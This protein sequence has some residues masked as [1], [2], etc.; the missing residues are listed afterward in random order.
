MEVV[1]KIHEGLHQDFNPYDQPANT[2]QDN[3]NGI[4]MDMQ[5][6]NYMWTNMKGTL[7]VFQI[8]DDD[9][10]MRHCLIR[11]RLF[12]IVYNDIVDY[13]ILYELTFDNDGD[14]T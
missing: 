9:N 11:D 2:M 8:E 13:V 4:I 3:R 14:I 7:L 1:N 12:I 6:G 5:D 10:I